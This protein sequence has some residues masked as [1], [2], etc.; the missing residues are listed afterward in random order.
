MKAAIVGCGDISGA[1][2]HTFQNRLKGVELV[3]CANRSEARLRATAEKYNLRPMTFA[4][5]LTSPEIEM[6]INLTIKL[7]DFLK[8]QKY[9]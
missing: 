1:Y 4:G 6:V 5:I 9:L 3:A 7:I 8:A 2:I